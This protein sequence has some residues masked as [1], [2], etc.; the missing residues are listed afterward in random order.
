MTHTNNN[1]VKKFSELIIVFSN[2][3][4]VLTM[5]KGLQRMDMQERIEVEKHK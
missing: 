1:I 3:E 2:R 4:L 5:D